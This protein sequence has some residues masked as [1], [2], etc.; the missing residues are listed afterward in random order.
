MLQGT[1]PL[2]IDCLYS[3]QIEERKRFISRMLDIPINHE[4]DVTTNIGS[5]RFKQTERIVDIITHFNLDPNLPLCF[6]LLVK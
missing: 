2:L 6:D 1:I 3:L 5:I 4:F